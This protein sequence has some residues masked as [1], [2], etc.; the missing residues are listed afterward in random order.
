MRFKWR[1]GCY[2]DK[3]YERGEFAAEEGTFQAVMQLEKEL[4]VNASIWWFNATSDKLKKELSR[5]PAGKTKGFP[6]K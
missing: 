2:R 1:R 6:E 5:S 4:P 3:A